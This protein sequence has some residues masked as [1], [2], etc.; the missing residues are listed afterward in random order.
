MLS[1]SRW[2]FRRPLARTAAAPVRRFR[3]GLTTLDDRIVPDGE[4]PQMFVYTGSSGLFEDP[5]QA[6]PGAFYVDRPDW[7]GAPAIDVW[8]QLGGT[9]TREVDYTV[10]GGT[11]DAD[12]QAYHLHL[13]YGEGS[14]G[15]QLEVVRDS[16]YEPNGEYIQAT[17]LPVSGYD[18]TYASDSMSITD[19]PLGSITGRVILDTGSTSSYP[20]SN[21][22]PSVVGARVRLLDGGS[23]V[24]ETT[25]GENG[26]YSFPLAEIGE[27]SLEVTLPEGG[28]FSIVA[29][30]ETV[31]VGA[32]SAEY[33]SVDANPTVAVGL[34]NL[35][36][37]VFPP[38]KVT[39]DQL[40]TGYDSLRSAIDAKIVT[41]AATV[42]LINALNAEQAII[43]AQLVALGADPNADP[44]EVLRLS[45]RNLEIN[46]RRTDL[47]ADLRSLHAE[48]VTM[49][50][51]A[52]GQY[53][54]LFI[55]G[56]DAQR[57]A[58]LSSLPSLL[59]QSV[60]DYINAHFPSA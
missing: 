12:K 33:F 30:G 15:I 43:A 40:K 29:G 48:Y 54:L 1:L 22:T 51:A 10:S 46:L 32:G 31:V 38:V 13:G 28:A 37:K 24:G 55:L 7:Q 34:G 17:L 21:D 58:L 11:W 14:A 26:A 23:P 59:P 42:N 25:S 44:A 6:T 4:L 2:L 49:Y 60:V 5:E 57:A 19:Y 50:D 9:A 8:L 18:T 52:S 27:Y 45:N 3:P 41:M 16:I 47:E 36:L 20:P 56:S 35:Q 53:S 39:Y